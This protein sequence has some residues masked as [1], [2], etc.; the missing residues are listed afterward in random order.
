MTKHR[1]QLEIKRLEC[2]R[3]TASP[4]RKIAIQT[5]IEYLKFLQA[6]R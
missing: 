5:E 3:E 4:E 1:I 6:A 2:E